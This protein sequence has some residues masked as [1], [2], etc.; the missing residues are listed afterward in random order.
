MNLQYHPTNSELV[1]KELLF[2]GFPDSF[3]LHICD[4]PYQ[5]DAYRYTIINQPAAALSWLEERVSRIE[6]FQ[7]PFA[8]FCQLDWLQ[9]H[10]EAFLGQLNAHPY[11]GSVPVI[12]LAPQGARVDFARMTSLGLDDCYTVFSNAFQFPDYF[13]YNLDALEDMLLDLDWMEA[14]SIV[15]QM[16]AP[17]EFLQS[18]STETKQEVWEL[19]RNLNNPRLV[20]IWEEK[21]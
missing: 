5:S 4:F 7:L 21:M 15:V 16:V 17:N 8:I 19:L 1:M 3:D 11:L 14:D 13:G 9:W 12:A 2:T 10:G 18:E 20:F 6:T